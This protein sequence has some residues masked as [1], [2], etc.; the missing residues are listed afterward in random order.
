MNESETSS[1]DLRE[2]FQSLQTLFSVSMMLVLVFTLCMDLFLFRQM[3]ILRA[4]AH[5]LETQLQE[6]SANTAPAMIKLYSQMSD[7][8]AKHPE[9]AAI[10]KKYSP[11]FDAHISR[12]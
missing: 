7:Y 10:L 11:Y 2:R 4:E 12:K 1:N 8:A 9:Y 5:R 6:F 3:L